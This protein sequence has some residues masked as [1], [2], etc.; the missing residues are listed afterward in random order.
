[1]DGKWIFGLVLVLALLSFSPMNAFADLDDVSH[2]YSFNDG[3]LDN[4]G[5]NNLVNPASLNVS[6][7]VYKLGNASLNTTQFYSLGVP[8]PAGV[9]SNTTILV[10]Q[11]KTVSL[12]FQFNGKAVVYGEY[13][14]MFSLGSG[15]ASNDGKLWE[16]YYRSAQDKIHVLQGD[17]VGEYQDYML[18]TTGLVN[19]GTWYNLIVS[20]TG[21]NTPTFYLN[22]IS[23]TG[24][25]ESTA[26]SNW[27]V[28]GELRYISIG[29]DSGHTTQTFGGFLDEVNFWNRTL[30]SD[31][32]ATLYDD[33][34]GREYPFGSLVNSFNATLANITYRPDGVNNYRAYFNVTLNEAYGTVDYAV[35][36]AINTTVI[37]SER[38][39]PSLYS[40]PHALA[41]ISIFSD[42]VGGT[43]ISNYITAS[44]LSFTVGGG[45]STYFDFVRTSG[46]NYRNTIT[47]SVYYKATGNGTYDLIL[48]DNDGTLTDYWR[49]VKTG[50]NI[51][52]YQVSGGVAVYKASALTTT[53]HPTLGAF[54]DTEVFA[55]FIYL[56]I[57]NGQYTVKLKMNFNTIGTGYTNVGTSV[58]H[59]SMEFFTVSTGTVLLK[60]TFL[61]I[62]PAQFEPSLVT[63]TMGNIGTAY[64]GEGFTVTP[65]NDSV[66]VATCDYPSASYYAQKHYVGSYNNS[67]IST[68]LTS[69]FSN[70]VATGNSAQLTGAETD[71]LTNSL[72]GTLGAA[73]LTSTGSKFLV[74]FVISIIFAAIFA[75]W[76]RDV[77]ALALTLGTI[78]FV[79]LMSIGVYYALIPF[80]FIIVVV[81]ICGSLVAI[82][83]KTVFSTGS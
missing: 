26:G 4:V 51:S 69:D 37:W 74:W 54:P 43:N 59:S 5:G 53:A 16:V 45:N 52:F 21:N 15:N 30:T 56:P 65:I 72:T 6:G 81:I 80:W 62:D 39:V 12:W 75:F 14:T 48:K 3:F 50:T 40:V 47:A 60:T 61:G 71:D 13:N 76:V 36:C 70:A 49:M 7:S 11:T 27:N 34:A 1:M 38:Y 18:N 66:L 46:Q 79:S 23:Y 77:P 83:F 33:G 29:T 24:V 10:P 35:T 22:G 2:S 78:S 57:G 9:D 32:I 42:S 28:S 73:G 58:Y 20:Q 67:V 82:T 63:V 44:G 8:V 25:I 68:I 64:E 19:T 41:N 31:E 17:G 55:E